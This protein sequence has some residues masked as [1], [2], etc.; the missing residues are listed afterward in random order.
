M[1]ESKVFI[2]VLNWNNSDDTLRCLKS[3]FDLSYKNIEIIVV[4]NN[5]DSGSIR[6]LEESDYKF[7][8]IK[9]QKNLGYTG[10]NNLAMRYAIENDADY[11]WLFNND[12]I[13]EP[14]ML[15][16]LISEF[17]KDTDLGIVSPLV[18]DSDSDNVQFA[19]GI[20]DLRKPTYTPV[21]DVD[22][23]FQYL[24]DGEKNIAIVGTAMLIR[25]ELIDKIGYLDDSI[26]A[27]WEDI[28]YSIRSIL[29]GFKNKVLYSSTLRHPPKKTITDPST[30]KPH[31][32]YFMTRNEIKMWRKHCAPKAY[33][34]SI[35]WSIIRV[36]DQIIR[37]KD[38]HDAIN[39]ILRGLWDGIRGVDG[40][41]IKEKYRPIKA[42][43]KFVRLNGYFLNRK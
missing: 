19:L 24:A 1:M 29:S 7:T 8:L 20:F 3:L 15:T 40:P 37:L 30:V 9:S 16:H 12:A 43:G 11:V 22:V 32:Y 4:D 42:V 6:K 35:Y 10:G 18:K 13:A 14:D 38:Y 21:Y 34:R 27:Y 31:Y 26:F 36:H 2:S 17:H 5:S 25:R 41:Y 39:A 23:A 33:L 28:D